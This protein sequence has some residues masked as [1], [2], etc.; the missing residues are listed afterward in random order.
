M[1]IVNKEEEI[2]ISKYPLNTTWKLYDHQKSGSDD[3]D[4]NTRYIGSFS[5]VVTFWQYFNHIPPPSK[6]FYQVNTGK[7][8]Y[9][10]DK[11]VKRE[12]SSIS[13]FRNNIQPKWEDPINK[14]GGEIN[15]KNFFKKQI[16]PILYLD[17]LW[18]NLVLSCIGEIFEFSEEVTGIRVVDSS[19][20]NKPLYRIEMWFSNL[21]HAQDM[22]KN[23]KKILCLNKKDKIFHKKHK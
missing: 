23:F 20:P 6:L 4:K 2:E 1:E 18:E 15:L 17:E 9:Q 16:Q 19:I 5:D 21:D 3:Y 12:I 14:M 13:L 11:D 7:P 22:E 8:Y 10:L